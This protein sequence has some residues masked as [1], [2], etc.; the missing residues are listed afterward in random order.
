M[1]HSTHS[2]QESPAAQNHRTTLRQPAPVAPQAQ[3]VEP[4][5]HSTE[6]MLQLQRTIGNQAVLR[7]IGRGRLPAKIGVQ[8]AVSAKLDTDQNSAA[9]TDLKS[10]CTKFGIQKKD[11]VA[12]IK[13][14]LFQGALFPASYKSSYDTNP[15]LQ[16]EISKIVFALDDLVAA[17][18]SQVVISAAS[19]DANAV[20]AQLFAIIS[21]GI[22]AAR[23]NQYEYFKTATTVG[24]DKAA[25]Y[26]AFIDTAVAKL[27]A[28][29]QQT[30]EHDF[31]EKS[32]MMQNRIDHFKEQAPALKKELDDAIA[33]QQGADVTNPIMVRIKQFVADISA[34]EHAWDLDFLVESRKVED[35]ID[36][37]AEDPALG[38]HYQVGGGVDDGMNVSDVY[39]PNLA[40]TLF[41]ILAVK[42]GWLGAAHPSDL[43]K[44]LRK[45]GQLKDY[46]DDRT[47]A[48]IRYLAGLKPTMVGDQ[49][50]KVGAFLQQKKLENPKQNFL[51]DAEGI[52]HT[53]AAAW[54]DGDYKKV[55]EATPNGGGFGQYINKKVLA[56]WR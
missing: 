33:G 3:H 47:A 20:G 21:A 29:K 18:T 15:M 14:A 55:D 5:L 30:S 54:K 7:M 24:V 11:L 44:I 46:D 22:N 41:A 40:C 45:T 8:R 43:H 10:L 17:S 31:S 23:L 26:I 19:G 37:L 50:I 36:T 49:D 27:T 9:F 13:T 51:F 28:Y 53:F 12:P 2:P 52:A 6:G 32:R 48:K 35:D 25:D 42:P 4:S 16:Q 1:R 38:G 56:I 39:N 34:L